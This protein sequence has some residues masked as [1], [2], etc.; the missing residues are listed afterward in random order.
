M[1][2]QFA[3]YE[4]SLVI[5]YLIERYGIETLKRVLTDL[6]AGMPINESL[7]RYTGS[8]AALDKEFAAFAQ[9]RAREFA[10][11]A[12]WS[13]PDVP[14]NAGLE[15]LTQ[16]LNQHPDNYYLLE[17]QAALLLRDER[18]DQARKVLERMLELY[19]GDETARGR[20][21]SVHRNSGNRDQELAALEKWLA[22]SCDAVPAYL[23]LIELYSADQNWDGVKRAAQ[24]LLGSNPLLPSP[25]RAL[26]L[27]AEATN[28]DEVSIAALKTTL[29]MSPLDEVDLRY[30]L[31]RLLQKKGHLDEAK[32]HALFAL[33]DAPRFRKGHAQLLEI[34]RELEKSRNETPPAGTLPETPRK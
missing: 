21:V 6:G 8:L 14:A 2:L 20:L 24:K 34:V 13:R 16:Q 29:R 1:H 26:A 28:D 19:P 22:I 27:A 5:E 12:D 25:H 7:Q 17:R 23:R 32:R 4:S 33:E 18:W 31:A 15:D 3:Y 30:R 9:Q 10:A 11:Q